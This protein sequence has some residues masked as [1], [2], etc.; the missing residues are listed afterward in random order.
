MKLYFMPTTRAVRPR[1]L[2]EEMGIDYELINVSMKMSY[3]PE[4]SRLHPHAKVPVLVDDSIT[5]FES[6]AICTY[7]ADKYFDKNFAPSINSPTRAYYYQWLF[8]ASQ[9]LEQPVEQYMFNILPNLPD[10]LLPKNARTRLT[11]EE[12][13]QWF[14]KVCQPLNLLL[15]NNDFI[16]ENRFTTVDVVTGGVLLWALKLGM[17]KEESPVKSY[18]T[19]LMQRAAFQNADVDV[20]AKV[21]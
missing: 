17:L 1:W 16:V 8:Y 15:I 6:A 12:A 9:T 5:I 18:I 20:Y 4:Y 2:L 10:K 7:L 21:G 13:L 3:E 19:K 14:D 11:P